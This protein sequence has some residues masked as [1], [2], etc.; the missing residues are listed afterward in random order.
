M[1]PKRRRVYRAI[2]TGSFISFI[3]A[4]AVMYGA[5]VPRATSVRTYD[6][7]QQ[8]HLMQT[9]NYT[10]DSAG[11]DNPYVSAQCPCSQSQFAVASI[12]NASIYSR[13]TQQKS[14]LQPQDCQLDKRNTFCK[15]TFNIADDASVSVTAPCLDLVSALLCNVS[16]PYYM[17]RSGQLSPQMSQDIQANGALDTFKNMQYL[18]LPMLL[19]PVQLNSTVATTLLGECLASVV[20]LAM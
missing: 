14:L 15:R 12:V 7:M 11:R 1:L 8:L 9:Y 5:L 4:M 16:R 3:A 20:L 10:A 6:M 18:N 13:V 19:N 17:D 2:V